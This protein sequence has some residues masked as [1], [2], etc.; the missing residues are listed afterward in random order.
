M[1]CKRCS[2]LSLLIRA[3]IGSGNVSVSV[4]VYLG[5]KIIVDT[6]SIT[7]LRSSGDNSIDTYKVSAIKYRYDNIDT[8]IL[9]SLVET[10]T[11]SLF[12]TWTS[13]DLRTSEC[14]LESPDTDMQAKHWVRRGY[15]ETRDAIE[16]VKAH[17]PAKKMN[18]CAIFHW[19]V[20]WQSD[21]PPIIL[22]WRS[23]CGER[24]ELAEKNSASVY[25]YKLLHDD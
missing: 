15:G 13:L 5:L 17:S 19:N 10:M 1:K 23:L 18:G 11:L 9:T 14:L 3:L 12:E 16:W 7:V 25:C 6:L 21:L 20:R 8:S 24:H 2:V 22:T 4:S